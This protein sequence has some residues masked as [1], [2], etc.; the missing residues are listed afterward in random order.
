MGFIRHG[1]T[2][3]NLA[4]RM[5]GHMDTE[6]AEIGIKQAERLA[7]RL[8]LDEWDG[9]MSS[10]LIRAKQTAQTISEVT[11]T[12]FLGTDSRLRERHF[13]QLE[14]TTLEDR[15]TLF[16]ESWR[17]Q[18]LGLESDE[19]LLQRWFSFFEELEANHPGKRI[20]LVSHGGYI[21]PVLEHIMGKPITSHL[22]NTS[23]TVMVLSEGQVWNCHLLNC[24]AHLD[25][26]NNP[27]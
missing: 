18:D 24:T 3:W 14:G 13:G 25:D 21:A 10:D 16:G 7:S 4:G 2:E 9:L 17:E 11:G 6:L 1:T 5:Q 22:N 26:T 12:P 23:L 8:K 20:L 19:L 27:Q 15:I